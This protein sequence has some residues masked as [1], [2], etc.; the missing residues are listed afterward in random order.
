MATAVAAA[1]VPLWRQLAPPCNKLYFCN[2]LQSCTSALYF[3]TFCK[4]FQSCNLYHIVVHFAYLCSA[5]LKLG[6][7]KIFATH[8]F[9]IFG[10]ALLCSSQV[11]GLALLWNCQPLFTITAF[12]TWAIIWIP[13]FCH[14]PNLEDANTKYGPNWPYQWTMDMVH[15]SISSLA[16]LTSFTFLNFC[17]AFIIAVDK[18]WFYLF[19]ET[20]KNAALSLSQVTRHIVK[21]IQRNY[22][23]FSYPI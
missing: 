11:L 13:L 15:P 9:A 21:G 19:T 7:M 18:K 14:S 5:L 12:T 10:K 2:P 4:N 6:V 20:K 16:S 1:A 3:C 23:G 22:I 17:F 8:Y